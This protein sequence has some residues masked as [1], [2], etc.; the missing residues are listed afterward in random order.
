[1]KLS[2][3]LFIAAAAWQISETIQSAGGFALPWNSML[4]SVDNALPKIVPACFPVATTPIVL[5]GAGL[6]LKFG[7]HR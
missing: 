3:W 4:Y 7:F 6:V 5:A 2:H 1:M